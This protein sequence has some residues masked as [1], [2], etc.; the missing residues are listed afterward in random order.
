MEIHVFKSPIPVIRSFIT[1]CIYK[2]A[3]FHTQHN[4]DNTY[5]FKELDYINNLRNRI[6]HHEPVCFDANDNID[7]F[8]VMSRYNKM[9]KLFSWL[10]IDSKDLL[11]G[12]DHVKQV[13]AEIDLFKA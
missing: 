1:S 4:Y 5:I 8:Y 11:Y 2:Q 13:C 9:I 7:T 3:T 10:G 12:L 6:A